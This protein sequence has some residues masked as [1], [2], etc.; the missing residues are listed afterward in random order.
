MMGLFA[1]IRHAWVSID[2]ALYLW[3]YTHPDPPLVGY[4]EQSNCI[5][6]V[7]MVKPRFGVF[8]PAITHLLVVATTAEIIL[9]GVA[10]EKLP[11]GT[12]TV[13]LY[14]TNMVVPVRGLNVLSIAGT[15]DGRIFFTGTSDNDVYELTYQQ[16]EKW[17]YSRCAK[18]NHTSSRLSHIT[19]SFIF[20]SRARPEMTLQ[21][22]V[23]DTRRLVYSLST[24]SS[25]RIFYMQDS[26]GLELAITKPWREIL[27]H[28]GHAISQTDLITEQT[29][30]VSIHPISSQEAQKI[31]LVAVTDTGC[32][33]YL[34]ATSSYGYSTP[35]ETSAPLS[36][37][38]HHVKFPPPE[39]ETT[40]F[41][42]QSNQ[43]TVATTTTGTVFTDSPALIQT[44][45]AY[46]YAPGFF[47]CLVN[48]DASNI[49]ELFL[50]APDT[51]RINRPVDVAL[52]PRFPE[53]AMWMPLGSRAEAVDQITEGFSA[54][55]TPSGFGN[56]LAVQY[57]KSTTEIAIL[58]NTGVHTIR[59]QRL[60]DTFVSAIRNGKSEEGLEGTMRKFIRFYGRT[61]AAA[62]ALAV[63]CGQAMEVSS[64]F[65]GVSVTDPTMLE[66]ART[67]FIEYG[68]KPQLNENALSESNTLGI[69]NV[70]PSP[71]HDGLAVYISRLVRSFWNSRVVFEM[72]TPA[73]GLQVVSTT[74]LEKLNTTQHDLN[75]L[76]EF[77]DANKNFID[78]LAGPEAL[79][80]VS[81][82][83]QE[84]A[85]QAEHRAL[86]AL[87]SLISNIIEGISF[88]QMLFSERLDEIMLSLNP[89]VYAS[90]KELTYADLFSTA[91][92]KEIAKELV[93]AIVNRNILN[94]SNVETVADALRRRCG[95]FCSPAD[96]I[97]FK[98]QEQLRRAAE[99]GSTTELGR[100]LLNESIRLFKEAASELSLEQ[101]HVAIEQ[102]IGMQFFAGAISLCLVVA[103]EL[104]RGN[105]AL[106]WIENGRSETVSISRCLVHTCINLKLGSRQSYL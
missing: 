18:V 29:R 2:N 24:A 31:S 98:A 27:N 6:A 51:G 86:H 43:S 77:L 26:K 106:L 9:I 37:Q 88:V 102:Y 95:S 33:I 21:L 8:V 50:S 40:P 97:I 52:G 3:D 68:G 13:T 34:S 17:F 91:K 90:V 96:V 99:M 59:R 38:V 58:T 47:L 42:N 56:E 15:A 101:L 105:R 57:D 4:E 103:H 72:A 11:V 65:R 61:E 80:R 81:T 62:T 73:G 25:I 14:E 69:D 32:R 70:K 92:G 66:Q 87:L 20:S 67:A 64:D 79:G 12:F 60:V 10:L 46:R 30:I 41:G 76:K 74:D 23:D 49:D 94:G 5:T 82:R 75:A 85:L 44:R 104:D 7:T 83:Q 16:E 89:G 28:I 55:K 71:R 54:A 35:G 1:N 100:N 63:A 22:I 78:G 36:M 84:I 45:Q 48:R 53:S 93:K 19:P 39:Q